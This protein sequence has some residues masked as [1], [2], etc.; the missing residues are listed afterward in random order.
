MSIQKNCILSFKSIPSFFL[1]ILSLLIFSCTNKVEALSIDE[2]PPKVFFT[3]NINS[4]G[5]LSVFEAL[6]VEPI[7]NV[8]IKVHTGE[9]GNVHYVKP[10]M[11]KDL[12]QR[13]NGTIVETNVAYGG[14]RSTTAS[15]LQV[16]SDHGFTDI[17]PV[18]ILDSVDDISFPVSAGKHLPENLVGGLFN[19]F[20][21]H[22]VISHFK[23]HQ[24][25]GFGG[26][27]KNISIGYASASGKRLIHAGGKPGGNI[28]G[29][30]Q[31]VFLESMVEAAKTITENTKDRIVYINIMNHLSVDCDCSSSPVAPE[32]ADIGILASLDPVALDQACV[33][34]VF[35][36]QDGAAL[37]ERIISRQAIRTL[38]YAQELNIGSRDY[39]LV[40][41]P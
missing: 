25:G 41:L 28:W 1:L 4:E 3:S 9:P 7:G 38:E 36:A 13:L 27:L 20:D 32:M 12:V 17:A 18:L 26:A 16:A 5:I 34:L 19:D 21:F 29:T 14:P 24:M 37:R 10:D 11:I 23:G 33:D 35:A 22:V 2:D 15:H 6:Q 30:D 40:I 8:A 39:Q 31:I